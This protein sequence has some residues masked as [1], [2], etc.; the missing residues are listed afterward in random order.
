[1]NHYENYIDEDIFIA[2]LRKVSQRFTTNKKQQSK[3]MYDD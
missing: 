1:M 3:I 2:R